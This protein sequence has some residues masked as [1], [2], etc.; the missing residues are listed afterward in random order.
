VT[1]SGQSK[2]LLELPARG[3]GAPGPR[4]GPAVRTADALLQLGL[5]RLSRRMPGPALLMRL[6]IRAVWGRALERRAAE[7]RATLRRNVV[8]SLT[9]VSAGAGAGAGIT[10]ILWRRR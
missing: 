5:A 10:W 1:V 3:A 6:A 9:A 8:R 2:L 4:S 7:R